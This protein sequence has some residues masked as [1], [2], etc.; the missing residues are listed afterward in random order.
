MQ[1]RLLPNSWPGATRCGRHYRQL[2]I[3]LPAGHPGQKTLLLHLPGHWM[4]VW[5]S[6]GVRSKLPDL[7]D[8][9]IRCWIHCASYYGYALRFGLVY[10]WLSKIYKH[11]WDLHLL[12]PNRDFYSAVSSKLRIILKIKSL[13]PSQ[14]NLFTEKRSMRDQQHHL[15]LPRSLSRTIKSS[16]I[17]LK[18][19]KKWYSYNNVGIFFYF[20]DRTRGSKMPDFVYYT[21]KHCLLFGPHLIS[22]CRLLG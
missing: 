10:I 2:H 13:S 6:H 18:S 3:R 14:T 21:F 11:K 5:S 17:F 9:Q 20:S 1:Q 7:G 22:W 4:R 16:T 15:L 19:L 12:I 8:L